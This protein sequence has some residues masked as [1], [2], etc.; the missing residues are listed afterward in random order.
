MRTVS[1]NIRTNAGDEK[2]TDG[3]IVEF[4]LLFRK[5]FV[6]NLIPPISVVN[7]VLQQNERDAQNQNLVWAPFSITEDEYSSICQELSETHS[8]IPCAP[9]SDE[10]NNYFDWYLYAM[11]HVFGV[12][13]EPH[14]SI[15]LQLRDCEK[16]LEEAKKI[17]MDDGA[18]NRIDSERFLKAMELTDFLEGY[19]ESKD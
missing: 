12:P 18:I 16:R 13:I 6:A 2:I 8:L 7:S 19:L 14:R 11:N 1:Y 5:L 17:G 3:S 15:E 10:V 9:A 4:L